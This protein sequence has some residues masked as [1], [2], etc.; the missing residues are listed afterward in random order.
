MAGDL[1]FRFRFRVR[2]GEC[3]AMVFKPVM[4]VSLIFQ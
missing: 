3:D 4:R 1:P 2:Y